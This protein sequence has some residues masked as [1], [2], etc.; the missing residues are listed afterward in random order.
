MC[1]AIANYKMVYPV[2]ISDQKFKDCLDLL[3][4][5]KEDKSQYVYIE[6][7]NRFMHNKTKCKN[8][9]HF[10]RYCLQHFSSKTVLAEHKETCLKIN[11]K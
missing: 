7:F 8:K 3:L 2:H 10:C 4:T 6:H 5:T 11:V 1:F 9:K